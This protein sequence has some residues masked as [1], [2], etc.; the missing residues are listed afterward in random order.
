MPNEPKPLHVSHV[1]VH[2]TSQHT[3]SVQNPLS[4]SPAIEH[5]A[6]LLPAVGAT[7]VISTVAA[8][9][10]EFGSRNDADVHVA[11][12]LNVPGSLP[13]KATAT[14][15]VEPCSLD[16]ESVNVHSISWAPV[17]AHSAGRSGELGS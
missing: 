10:G 13:T 2:A 17:N 1:P 8:S 9:S 11:S 12:T 14:D 16:G 3:P 15:C 6:P 4:Q 7:T 5:G